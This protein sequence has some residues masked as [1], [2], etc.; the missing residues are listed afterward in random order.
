[1]ANIGKIGTSLKENLLY[2]PVNW[3]GNTNFIKNKLGKRYQINDG[4]FIAAV[5]VASVVGKDAINCGLYTYQSLHNES[6]PEDKRPFVAALDLT[7]GILMM[8]TQVA[9]TLGF[10][11]VQNKVFN[12]AFGKYFDRAATKG[13]KSVLAKTKEFSGI[14]GDQFHPAFEKYKGNV[15]EAFKQITTLAIATIVAKRMIVPFLSTP[16]ADK[17][18]KWMMQNEQ[19][20]AQ[21]NP[22]TQNSFDIEKTLDVTTADI[23]PENTENNKK[24]NKNNKPEISHG[25]RLIDTY[26]KS[27]PQ[28]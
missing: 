13:Y 8:T 9:V 7:N 15:A 6:I 10:T 1:M 18:K 12:K 17:A 24:E 19:K 11:K 21:V 4:N 16:L 28:K 22:E 14:G 5:G 2:K 26:V 20:E 23:K 25:T 3:L 27:H